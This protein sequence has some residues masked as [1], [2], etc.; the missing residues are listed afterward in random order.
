MAPVST[1][2]RYSFSRHDARSGMPELLIKVGVLDVVDVTIVQRLEAIRDDVFCG[3]EARRVFLLRGG[4][5]GQ[6]GGPSSL[7]HSLV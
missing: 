1:G 6:R 3:D 7:I 4:Q 5:G 2:E